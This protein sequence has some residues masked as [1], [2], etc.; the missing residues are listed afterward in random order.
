M[1]FTLGLSL[2]YMKILSLAAVIMV[3]IWGAAKVWLAIYQRKSDK[4]EISES[5]GAE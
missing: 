5:G 4:S 1:E 3:I 2:A